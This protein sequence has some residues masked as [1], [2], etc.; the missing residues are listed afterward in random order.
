L[1]SITSSADLEHSLSGNYA[2]GVLRRGRESWVVLAVPDD[3]PNDDSSRCLT[4]ALLWL[5]RL[6]QSSARNTVLGVRILLPENTAAPV[7][8]LSSALHPELRV[9]LFERDL[10]MERLLR[11]EPSEGANFTWWIVPAR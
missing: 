1:D 3:E 2:R 11:I 6:R 7:A 5:D 9:Q 8:H 10:V 4:F